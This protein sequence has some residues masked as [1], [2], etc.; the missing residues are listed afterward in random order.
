[1]VEAQIVAYD[2]TKHREQFFDLLLEYG[3]EL[4]KEVLKNYGILLIQPNE[5]QQIYEKMFQRIIATK[6]PEGIVYILEVDGEAAGTGRLSKLEERIG[7]IKNMYIRP[8][9]RGNGYSYLLL[10]SLEDKAREFG[11]SALR[12]DT[13]D[14]NV[15]A[16]HIY[17]KSGYDEIER[18]SE[19]AF[20]DESTRAYYENK[21]YME[22]KL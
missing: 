12:L 16:Q 17:N 14:F 13:A 7:E 8:E 11:Y 6:P 2:D 4:G 21:K 3:S 10:H 5:S 18:Y 1:M 9:Y 22:K 15:V 19:G 20:I